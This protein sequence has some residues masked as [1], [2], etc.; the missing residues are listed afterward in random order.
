MSRE[1]R[2][3]F[4]Q[5]LMFPPTLEQ[6]VGPEH[7]ARFVRD[8]VAALDLKALGFRMRESGE[9]APNYAPDLVLSAWIYGYMNKIR[10]TRNLAHAC[11]ENMGLIWL[12]GDT[13]PSHNTLSRF[14]RANRGPL[15]KIFKQS[16]EVAM[17]ADL[18]GLVLHAVDGTK[19]MANSSR[20]KM[21]HREDLEKELKNLDEAVAQ[22]MQEIEDSEETQIGRYELPEAMQ[23]SAERK[24]AI[25]QAL[26][27]LDEVGRDH[28]SPREPEARLMKNG[29][30]LELSYNGQA[31]ADEKSGMIVAEEV[32]ND[33]NDTGQLVPM[34]EKVAENLGEVAQENLADGGY[35]S[36]AQIAGA[37]EQRYSVLTNRP[38]GEPSDDSQA[39][40]AQYHCSRF[41]YDQEADCVI[42]PQGKRLRYERT[43]KSKCKTYD[44]RVYRCKTFR[45]CA[46]A[47]KC[48]RDKRGRMIEISSYHAAVVRQRKKRQDLT[49][50]ELLKR[51]KA[52]IE[53]VFA[54]VKSHMGLRRWTVGGLDNVRVQW[55]LVCA[56]INLNKLYNHWVEGQFNLAQS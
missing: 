53:P 13:R 22:V 35:A 28:L 54:W 36:A 2:A 43:K 48:S 18:I 49:N 4:E 29:R 55:S 5:A 24:K 50:K 8:F 1:I 25:E 19:I 27:K 51:R 23:D 38:Q 33:E 14:W 40:K 10:S 46:H 16:V 39:A 52:I 37:E 17:E 32:V 9:G 44:L 21:W 15:R 45:E 11:R 12:T 34:L 20:R 6:W 41:T 56:A 42:C 31:V 3:N 26:K 47:G 30:G 7:P